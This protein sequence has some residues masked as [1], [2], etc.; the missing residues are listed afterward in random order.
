MIERL[1]EIIRRFAPDENIAVSEEMVLLTDFGLNSLELVEIICEVEEEFEIEIP[2]R[3]ISG[4]K[5][6]KDLM[7]YINSQ[8]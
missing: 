8:A 2:D 7:D 1:Q 5:T 3:A 4:F 6:V